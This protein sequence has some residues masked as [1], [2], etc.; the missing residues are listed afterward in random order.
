MILS[1]LV[2]AL[3]NGRIYVPYTISSHNVAGEYMLA[4]SIAIDCNFFASLFDT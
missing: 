3:A 4:M 1:G 2:L